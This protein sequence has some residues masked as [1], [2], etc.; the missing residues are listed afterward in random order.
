M[1]DNPK[2]FNLATGLVINAPTQT[3][4]DSVGRVTDVRQYRCPYGLGTVLY[5]VEAERLLAA[6]KLAW[7]GGPD[8]DAIK[9]K[10]WVF[11]YE[12]N[13]KGE[14]NRQVDLVT[15][16]CKK[17]LEDD[18]D[19]EYDDDE[20][21]GDEGEQDGAEVAIK[22]T[23]TPD[24]IFNS[25]K[26]RAVVDAISLDELQALKALASGQLTDE[27]GV[28]LID[29][30]QNVDRDLIKKLLRGQD[31]YYAP[32]T[33]ATIT[34]PR[35]TPVPEAGK[36]ATYAGLPKLPEGHRWLCMGG[37]KTKKDGK[38]VTTIT[39]LGGQWDEDLYK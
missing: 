29:K 30:L 22:T 38:K 5:K 32:V 20:D 6:F 8:A 35:S 1:P 13:I 34:K 28:N 9:G 16:T 36:I 26:Y 10:I 37:S 12:V 7:G 27:K 23:A 31:Q 24:S 15:V 17:D 21:E 19:E 33:E 3:D 2:S 11:T 18:P 4:I 39:F 25:D 14:A